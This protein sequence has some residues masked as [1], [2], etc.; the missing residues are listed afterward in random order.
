MDDIICRFSQCVVNII[1]FPSPDGVFNQTLRMY[2]G[3]RM[4][5]WVLAMIL[6]VIKQ[7]GF[8]DELKI[9]R[10]VH[11]DIHLDLRTGLRMWKAVCSLLYMPVHG[12]ETVRQDSFECRPFLVRTGKTYG[13]CKTIVVD[14]WTFP[15]PDH[16]A[17]LTSRMAKRN[18][19]IS[20]PIRCI[21]RV[22]GEHGTYSLCFNSPRTKLGEQL[23][24]PLG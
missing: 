5:A 10:L 15:A 13:H 18:P 23:S 8:S 2:R 11:R 16:L 12:F 3:L 22:C 20:F 9:L 14:S 6:L 21:L 1:P 19:F 17:C 7:N 24:F 4:K